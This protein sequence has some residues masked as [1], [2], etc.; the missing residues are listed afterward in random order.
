MSTIFPT[1]DELYKA[2]INDCYKILSVQQ[3]GKD[4]SLTDNQINIIYKINALKSNIIDNKSKSD[5]YSD[6]ISFTSIYINNLSIFFSK[7]EID[8]IY[9]EYADVYC[10]A[11]IALVG[12]KHNLINNLEN[13]EILSFKFTNYENFSNIL[14]KYNISEQIIGYYQEHLNLIRSKSNNNIY[15]NLIKEFDPE[16]Q[17]YHKLINGKNN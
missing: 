17:F 11:Y 15:L 16:N 14:V 12:F 5:K 6:I 2:I 13:D 3:N 4:K 8:D 9:V 1:F 10:L 7:N